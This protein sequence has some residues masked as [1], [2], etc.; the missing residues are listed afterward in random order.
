MPELVPHPTDRA[1]SAKR[2]LPGYG[3]RALGVL[4]ALGAGY[5]LL[6]GLDFKR[7]VGVLAEARPGFLL[8]VPAA[9]LAE[10]WVRAWKWGRIVTVTCKVPTGWAFRALMAGYVPGLVVGF[11]TSALARSWLLA[12]R[13]GERTSTLLATSTVDRLI[14]AFAFAFFIGLAAVTV[15]LPSSQFLLTQGLRWS[16]LLIAVIALLILILLAGLRRGRGG[17][18]AGALRLLPSRVRTRLEAAVAGYAHGIVWPRSLPRRAGIIA[19]ALFIKLIAVTQYLWA[20]LAFGVLLAPGDY[21]FIM[22]FLGTLVFL[23]FFVRVPG[24]GLLASLFALELL[25][26]AKAQ[27]LAMALTVIASFMLTIAVGGGIALIREGVGL[28][29]VVNHARGATDSRA[30]VRTRN[31]TRG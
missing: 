24:T 17:W 25:G 13:S 18:L 22:V 29:E 1:A 21:L 6:R 9:V 15:R 3:L 28:S 27:A 16:G 2:R 10:Q 30:A 4:I 31:D 26:V 19:A 20:G 8:L 23:D 14:D 7:L 5:W 11:G 12:R